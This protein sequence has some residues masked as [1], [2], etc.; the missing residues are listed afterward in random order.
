MLCVL[1]AADDLAAAGSFTRIKPYSIS[2]HISAKK[3]LIRQHAMQS[4]A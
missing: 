2:G 4:S 3:L 1:S